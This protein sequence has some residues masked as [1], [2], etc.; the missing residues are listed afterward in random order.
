MGI[1]L[2][3]SRE[4]RRFFKLHTIQ[5]NESSLY[6]SEFL[7]L[8]VWQED[9]HN[10]QNFIQEEDPLQIKGTHISILKTLNAVK[11]Y[12]S[13]SHKPYFT[14]LQQTRYDQFQK[15]LHKNSFLGFPVSHQTSF[16]HIRGFQLV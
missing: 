10:I 7:L 15:A 3:Q 13:H 16:P 12:C 11:R 5:N 4:L 14:P 2:S 1:C 6:L 8:W 9:A